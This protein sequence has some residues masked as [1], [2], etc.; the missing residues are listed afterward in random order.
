MWLAAL[1]HHDHDIDIRVRRE[2]LVPALAVYRTVKECAL[3]TLPAACLLMDEAGCNL[4]CI[5]NLQINLFR[6][7]EVQTG[8]VDPRQVRTA[9]IKMLF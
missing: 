3:K 7:R 2:L 4:L 6:S 1:V 5:T 8:D 9:E